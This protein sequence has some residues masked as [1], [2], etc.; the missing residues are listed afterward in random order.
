MVD[1]WLVL[2]QWAV[3]FKEMT[4]YNNKMNSSLCR[5]CNSCVI[6]AAGYSISEAASLQADEAEPRQAATLVF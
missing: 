2:R 1:F 4:M 3:I 5:L 6:C